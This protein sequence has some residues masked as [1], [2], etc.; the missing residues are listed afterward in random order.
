MK[1][2]LIFCVIFQMSVEVLGSHEDV[3][4]G[5]LRK[6]AELCDSAAVTNGS[7]CLR[8]VECK[9]GIVQFESDAKSGALSRVR[10]T[11]TDG[12]LTGY[13]YKQG[14]LATSFVSSSNAVDGVMTIYVP[15]Q[16]TNGVARVEFDF[17]G[18]K[19]VGRPRCIGASGVLMQPNPSRQKQIIDKQYRPPEGSSLKVGPYDWIVVGKSGESVLSRNGRILVSGG[20]RISAS[21]P[22]VVGCC[23]EENQDP[24]VPLRPELLKCGVRSP[25]GYT[26]YYA[27]LLDMRTDVVEYIRFEDA[28]SRM[29]ALGLGDVWMR[30]KSFWHYALSNHAE[31]NMRELTDGLK[32]PDDEH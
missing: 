24:G 12:G 6:F 16:G 31:E 28:D 26:V 15:H 3:A 22:W 20:I 29:L 5:Y 8:S 25:N 10:I 14:K 30:K 2:G 17:A 18:G 27:F 7:R 32:A 1:A 23:V 11:R 13:E 4:A 9:E 19:A 21:Y